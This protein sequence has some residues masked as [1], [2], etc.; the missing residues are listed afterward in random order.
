MLKSAV[1]LG[2]LITALLAVEL[3]IRGTGLAVKSYLSH[4][5]AKALSAQGSVRVMCVGDSMTFNQY[6]ATLE[7]LLNQNKHGLKFT[8]VDRAL[9]GTN[10]ADT[11]AGLERDVDA[12]KPD[13]VVSMM[14]ENDKVPGR[15]LLDTH[16]MADKSGLKSLRLYRLWHYT[17]ELLLKNKEKPALAQQT[18][19]PAA[20]QKTPPDMPREQ[21]KQLDAISAVISKGNNT[22]AEK[23]LKAYLV[24]YPRHADA[25]TWLG[26]TY[27][28]T[29]RFEQAQAEYQ[30][31]LQM[32]P[33][34]YKALCSL[35]EL[36]SGNDATAPQ[37]KPLLD[38]AIALEPDNHYAYFL[39]G[40]LCFNTGEL[41]CAR[42]N[43]SRAV[44]IKP[45]YQPAL[46]LLGFIYRATGRYED[47]K[48]TMLELLKTDKNSMAY[49]QLCSFYSRY[50]RNWE[51]FKKVA[52]QAL[53]ANLKDPYGPHECAG[54]A[55]RIF[56]QPDLS[57]RLYKRAM[58][59]APNDPNVLA[60]AAV[61]YMR[62]RGNRKKAMEL[63]EKAKR[64]SPDSRRA[65]GLYFMMTEK[66][67]ANE[68][69]PVPEDNLYAALTIDNYR[70]MQ[71]MLAPR[72]IPLVVMQYPARSLQPLKNIFPE[73]DGLYF[74]SNENL[75]TLAAQNGYARY[76]YDMYAG[77]FG[78]CTPEGN[79]VVAGNAAKTILEQVLKL[80]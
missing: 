6:P 18:P 29:G 77:D 76:F 5:N 7:R 23:L 67:G 38:K 50:S 54:E 43:L 53:K 80:K 1:V 9:P 16:G 2:G 46:P 73:T 31:T 39:R 62:E 41:E 30:R 61:F 75:K 72:R 13:I 69:S 44:E 15:I 66:E 28:K 56:K 48:T 11:M 68:T 22:Q 49:A 79:E 8:V 37:A 35:A 51:Q 26:Q 10:S 59:I 21:V 4:R 55:Y 3:G 25:Y 33:E 14:G 78:H 19:Q 12:Y 47:A 42:Q 57:E 45:G 65:T 20:S 64:L 24:K 32:D 36:W 63:A 70:K 52:D 27:A 71:Q 40:S 74:T 58:Q 60:T 17:R 34:N